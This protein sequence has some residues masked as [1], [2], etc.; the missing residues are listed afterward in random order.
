MAQSAGVLI[1][2][3]DGTILLSSTAKSFIVDFADFGFTLDEVNKAD[4]IHIRVYDNPIRYRYAGTTVTTTTGY[5]VAAGDEFE[6]VGK[7]IIQGFTC[8]AESTDANLWIT[9]TTYGLP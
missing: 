6:L 4:V 3:E 1:P 7:P 5:S 8:I 9:L 2:I